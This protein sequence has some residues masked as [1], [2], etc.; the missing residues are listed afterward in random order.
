MLIDGFREIDQNSQ[1]LQILILVK[2]NSLK[3][4]VPLG[5]RREGVLKIAGYLLKTNQTYWI[6][7]GYIQI[8]PINNLSRA[9]RQCSCHC[10]KSDQIR[11]F[12][13]SVFFRIW[14][15]YGDPL[16][17][18]RIIGNKDQKKLRIW[19]LSTQ[20]VLLKI[21]VWSNLR[22][23]MTHWK[24]FSNYILQL[25]DKFGGGIL[26]Y[27]WEDI[28]SQQLTEYKLPYDIESLFVQINLRKTSWFL[29]STFP[30]ANLLQKHY[31]NNIGHG[32]DFRILQI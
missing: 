23:S 15:E 6:T 31:L 24:K 30:A 13:L 10:V 14:T 11:S 5:G 7:Y 27:V 16:R 22:P 1:N 3:L 8:V 29:S 32:L 2:I 17:K 20:C 28:H 21:F 18:Y 9:R 25:L 26:I 4:Y 19:T 12:F